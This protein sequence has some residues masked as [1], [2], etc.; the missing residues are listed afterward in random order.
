VTSATE[1]PK[2]SPSQNTTGFIFIDANQYLTLYKVIK[3][4]RL[5]DALIEQQDHIFVTAQVA[6]EVQR[7]KLDIAAQFLEERFKLLKL[8]QLNIP[9][10]LFDASSQTVK[11]LQEAVQP[12]AKQSGPIE[13]LFKAA[14][15]ENLESISRS[16]DEVSVGLDKL[17]KKAVKHSDEELQR[18]RF[19]KERGNPPGKQRDV[20][21][22]QINWE[23]ILTKFK[24]TQKVWLISQD[25]DFF[26]KHEGRCILN[27]LLHRDL[28]AISTNPQC[29]CFHHIEE[30]IRDFARQTGAAATKLP[31]EKESIE[32]QKEWDSASSAISVA[33]S[34]ADELEAFLQHW[35]VFRTLKLANL[36][37]G[38]SDTPQEKSSSSDKEKPE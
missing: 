29:F 11:K 22:D 23:Q 15:A 2:I 33:S 32:I 31:S 37:F 28:A 3:G 26:M 7:R 27:P 21:G 4:K 5:L 8:D 6:D 19:R 9:D 1:K 20:L 18:A 25:S 24:D 38:Y 14:I 30:G 35:N 17:F 12:I 10:H 13:K 36:G 16:T 34:N